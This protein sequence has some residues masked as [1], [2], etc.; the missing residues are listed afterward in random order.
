MATLSPTTETA[1]NN[2]SGNGRRPDA[3]DPAIYYNA[4]NPSASIVIGTQK[5]A[6][7]S[8]YDLK[9]NEIQT[10]NPGN[11]RYN[12]ADIIYNFKLGSQQVDLAIASDRDNDS[13]SIFQINPSSQRLSEI[14]SEELSNANASIFGVD[15]GSNGAY[16]LATYQSIVDG[17]SYVFVTQNN[18]NKI[19]QLELTEDG[20]GKITASVVRTMTIPANGGKAEGLVID[21]ETG[22]LYVGQENFGIY[23]FDAE[24]NGGNSYTVVDR[25]KNGSGKLQSDVEGL[26]IDYSNNNLIAS[27]QGNSTFVIY[28]RQGNNQ[29]VDT[30][31]IGDGN[32]IDGVQDTDGLD[33]LNHNL[34]G[35]FSEGLLV[36]QDGQNDNNTTNFKY[37]S[38]AD[39]PNGNSD[40][41]LENPPVLAPQPNN[42]ENNIIQIGFQAGEDDYNGTVDTLVREGSPND[43]HSRSG[44][45]DADASDDYLGVQS[46]LRFENIIGNSDRIPA[47][48][49]IISARLELNITD[50]GDGLQFHSMNRGWSDR[51]T[52]HSLNDGIQANGIEAAIEPDAVTGSVS[53]GL[54]SINV[55]DSLREWQQNPD[56]NYGWAI[57]PTGSNGVDFDSS[58]SVIPPN[59]IVEYSVDN[60]DNLLTATSNPEI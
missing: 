59:L 4:N 9:G 14:T 52:W 13:L 38:L 41:E 18:S 47:T 8:V 22:T 1:S 15:D 39:L 32:G 34:G 30:F 26:T 11:V 7:L 33:I 28:D 56:S 12:N 6:G 23:K 5:D 57:L 48:A 40:K 25:V 60:S 42:G 36:V 31:N 58:E 45:L 49:K 53:T 51:D 29:L 46:L 20:V 2:N 21:R 55:T 50:E 54:L 3:D 44:F 19:A 17:K 27:S 43:D 37:V 24:V 10:V 35:E 16:G